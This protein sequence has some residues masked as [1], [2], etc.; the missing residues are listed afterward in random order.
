MGTCA[1]CHGPEGR[2]LEGQFPPLAGSEWVLAPGPNR[3]I[4]IALNGLAGPIK[5]L[6]RD[7]NSAEP[8]WR[9]VLSDEEI[10]AVLTY[11]RT[12]GKWGNTAAPVFPA[13]VK[14]IR[15]ATRSRTGPWTAAELQ[16]IP[17]RGD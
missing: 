1:V 4:R 15:E 16:A 7:F 11:V 3:L 5:V 10:A 9:D 2:G 13:Q 17:V 6:G 14:A 8:A 12:N